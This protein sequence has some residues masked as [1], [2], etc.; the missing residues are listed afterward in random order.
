MTPSARFQ[1]GM[2]AA[3][4]VSQL[5]RR[6]QQPELCW[7][8]RA[9]GGMEWGAWRR[10]SWTG[11]CRPWQLHAAGLQS[12]EKPCSVHSRASFGKV[13]AGDQ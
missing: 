11:C 7:Q 1:A 12:T 4:C 10:A 13:S 9:Q 2:R 3:E 8:E 5:Q 6:Q